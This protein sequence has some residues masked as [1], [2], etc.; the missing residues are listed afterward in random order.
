MEFARCQPG[1]GC[2]QDNRRP[3][4]RRRLRA[5]PVAPTGRAIAVPASSEGEAPEAIL[6][7]AGEVCQTRGNL[8]PPGLPQEGSL[9]RQDRSR[10]APC[11]G[12]GFRGFAGNRDRR[13]AHRGLAALSQ[14]SHPTAAGRGGGWRR[15][16]CPSELLWFALWLRRRA[17]KLLRWSPACIGFRSGDLADL[18]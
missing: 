8:P 13:L 1:M 15:Q 4:A 2:H 12:A 16:L 17:T 3:T 7:D 6:N 11:G 14:G 10:G 9:D 5:L 18:S